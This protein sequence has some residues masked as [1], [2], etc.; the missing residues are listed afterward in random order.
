[1]KDPAK[2]ERNGNVWKVVSLV[3]AL[4]TN[5]AVCTVGGFFLGKW[6]DKLW[7]GNGIGIGLGVLLG[8]VVGILSIVTLIKSVMGD[9]DG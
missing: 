1:M 6:L 9:K 5:F 3:T 4:G 8:I 2:P 7:F